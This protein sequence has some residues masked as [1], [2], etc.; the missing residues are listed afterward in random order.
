M[1][2]GKTLLNALKIPLT[3]VISLKAYPFNIGHQACRKWP[4]GCKMANFCLLYHNLRTIYTNTTK[5]FATTAEFNG[6]SFAIYRNE[7]LHSEWKI[8]VKI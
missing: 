4:C 5:I 8:L 3:G 2:A 6:L 1:L 7:I